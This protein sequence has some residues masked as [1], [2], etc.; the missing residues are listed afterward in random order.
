MPIH[1]KRQ[2]QTNFNVGMILPFNFLIFQFILREIHKNHGKYCDS[3]TSVVIPN[4]VT[5]I[6]AGAFGYCENLVSVIISKSVKSIGSYAFYFCDS[7]EIIKYRGTSSDCNGILKG[8][9]W[10][11]STGVYTITYNYKDE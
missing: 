9:Y 4:S 2:Y 8:N 3:L 10:N 11:Q 1:Y 7:L 6:G 5:S